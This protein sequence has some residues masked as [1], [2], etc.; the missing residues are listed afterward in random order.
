METLM[1]SANSVNEVFITVIQVCGS[2]YWC[3]ELLR[4]VGTVVKSNAMLTRAIRAT[5]IAAALGDFLPV[6]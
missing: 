6:K 5:K 2:M 4:I 3:D 1:P